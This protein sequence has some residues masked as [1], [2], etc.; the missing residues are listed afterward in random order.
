[1]DK[2]EFGSRIHAGRKRR[3]FTAEEFAKKLDVS[4]EHIRAIESG[5]RLPSLELCIEI[6]NVLNLSMD[7]LFS[8]KIVAATSIIINDITRNMVGLS[9]DDMCIV[10][11]VCTPLIEQ[12]KQRNK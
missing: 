11:S 1:M 10:E 3:D 4:V 6:A 2:K 5:R 9:H 7:S 12:L 8:K